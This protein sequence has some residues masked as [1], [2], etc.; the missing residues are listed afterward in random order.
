MSKYFIDVHRIFQVR[1]HPGPHGS[2]LGPVQ[3]KHKNFNLGSARPGK[4]LKFRTESV[5]ART[6]YKAFAWD[7]NGHIFFY[8]GPSHLSLNDFK[9]IPFS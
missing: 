7:R 5:Q 6:K 9:I 2:N 1:A 4:K 3:S 8:F